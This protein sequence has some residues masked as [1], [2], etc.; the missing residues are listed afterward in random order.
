MSDVSFFF[1]GWAPVLRIVVVGTLAYAALLAL[2]RVSGKRTLGQMNAFDML[3]TVA[4]GASFGRVLTARN[5]ALA[6]AVT[7]F[8]LLMLLQFGVAALRRRSARF[9]RLATAPPTLLF[10]RGEFLRARMR[11]ERVTEDELAGAVRQSGR[12]SFEDVEAILLEADGKLA[13]IGAGKAGDGS[14]LPRPD[15]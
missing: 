10:Y 15:P 6:E 8:A 14:L 1:G 5:V 12:G 3:I 11:D 9:E 13:V 4:L 7:A 2:H